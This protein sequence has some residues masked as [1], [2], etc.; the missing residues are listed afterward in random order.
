MKAVSNEL[1]A[2]MMW[3]VDDKFALH[4]MNTHRRPPSTFMMWIVMLYVG[5]FFAI[6]IRKEK[7]KCQPIGN[8]ESEN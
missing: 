1:S 3:I 5:V 7:C 2:F 4:I 6:H 8:Q